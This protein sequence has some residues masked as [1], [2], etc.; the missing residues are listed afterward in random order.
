MTRASLPYYD[1]IPLPFAFAGENIVY[2]PDIDPSSEGF[3]SDYQWNGST[4]PSKF[5][6]RQLMNKLFAQMSGRQFL[7]QCGCLDTFDDK[8]CSEIDGYPRGAILKYLDG[9][10]LYDVVSLVDS[11]KVDYTK[12]GIDNVNWKIYGASIFS[13]TYPDYGSHGTSNITSWSVTS[14]YNGI[15]SEA[16]TVPRNCFVQAFVDNAL[17]AENAVNFECAIL[18][19]NDSTLSPPSNIPDTFNPL[20]TRYELIESGSVVFPVF[21]VAG[22][23]KISALSIRTGGT[24][25]A[26]N[27]CLRF[28]TPLR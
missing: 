10:V 3:S 21:A 2:S 26:F 17:V 7:Q 18:L 23:T 19:S 8:V 13:Y 9:D 27:I 6:T 5:I 4:A 28:L 22:G 14:N 11:N 1:T 12:V 24:T 16:K 25:P 20:Y 15:L